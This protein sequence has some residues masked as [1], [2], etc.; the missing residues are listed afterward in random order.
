MPAAPPPP[1]APGLGELLQVGGVCGLSIG[2]GIFAGYLLDRALGTTPL[3]VF[4][5]LAVGIVGAAA[6]S[7]SVIRP[8]VT[9]GSERS[10]KPKD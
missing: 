9:D 3:L 5:G 7:Y 1:R 6:G 8:F 4:L 10:A 2:L